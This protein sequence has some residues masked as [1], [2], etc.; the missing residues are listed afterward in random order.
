MFV[1][2]EHAR[3]D[4]Q[5]DGRR[6]HVLGRTIY[7]NQESPL[8]KLNIILSGSARIFHTLHDVHDISLKRLLINF[9]PID[10]CDNLQELDHLKLL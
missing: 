9:P 2:I 8:H 3:R 10:A 5:A 6:A 7:Q 1:V 4:R